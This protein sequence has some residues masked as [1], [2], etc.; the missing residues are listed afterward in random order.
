MKR[1]MILLLVPALL[2]TAGLAAAESYAAKARMD[3]AAP[4]FTLTDVDGHEHSLADYKGKYV[5][6]E[7]TNMDCPFVKKHYKSGNMQGLQK[8]F[9]KE[10]VVW[11]RICS[12]AKGAQGYFK[13]AE[14]KR[15]LKEDKAMQTAY[16]ID[17]D[18]TVGRMYGAK[19]TPHM[20]VID[21]KGALIYAGGIDDK[22]STQLATVEGATNYV[23]DCL[24]AAMSGKP[25]AQKTAPPYGC[26]VK[27]A[28][29]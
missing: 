19:T 3:K 28:K 25:V 27:Y 24:Q 22:P 16:L 4:A 2:L 29:K 15:R 7:W 23:S 10:G 1:W 13:A 6:L 12:S 5:V 26:G 14:I 20:F 11:L 8:Q 17:A 21:P 9:T 18:G